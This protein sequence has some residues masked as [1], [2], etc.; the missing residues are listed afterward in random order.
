MAIVVTRETPVEPGVCALVISGPWLASGALGVGNIVPSAMIAHGLQ[1][2]HFCMEGAPKLALVVGVC[3]KLL[4]IAADEP[5]ALPFMVG[6]DV[7]ATHHDRPAGVAMSLQRTENPVCA[8][9]SEISAVL[10]SEPT[11]AALSDDAD[12]FEVEARPLAFDAFAFGVGAADVLAGRRPNDEVGKSSKVASDA[13][14]REVADI[15]ID[16]HSGVVFGV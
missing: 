2:S 11:R 7:V 8:A 4:D 6:A 12:G 9:S 15:V 10:K 13:I 5:C 3:I 1:L 16:Q 14:R